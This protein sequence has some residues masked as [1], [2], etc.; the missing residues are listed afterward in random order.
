MMYLLTGARLDEILGLEVGDVDFQR[1][2]I[3]FKANQWRP[4]KRGVERVIPLWPQLDRELRQYLG[5]ASRIG[6]SL[7]FPGHDH[8]GNEQKLWG[9][10]YTPLSRAAKKAKIDKHVTPQVFRVTYCA[11]RLQTLDNGQP[12]A[13][14]TV[15]KEMGH[16]SLSMI[17]SVY[18]RLGT[19]RH[20][21]ASV[22]Y[23]SE[24]PAPGTAAVA[25]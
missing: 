16:F 15:R 12:V 4:L 2:V 13:L 24:S 7:L 21:S 11:A 20:R 6:R 5:G 25:N 3:H 22:E 9:K 1:K 10:L 14:F 23:I 8:L 19:V 18:G 17:E